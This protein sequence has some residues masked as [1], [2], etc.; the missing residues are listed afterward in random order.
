VIC[1]SQGVCHQEAT[2]QN[3]EEIPNKHKYAEYYFPGY[4]AM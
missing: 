3:K 1:L 2:P 4:D